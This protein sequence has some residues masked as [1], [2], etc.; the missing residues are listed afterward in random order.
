MNLINLTQAAKDHL[1]KLTSDNNKKYV[2][3]EVKG[4]GCAGFKYDWSF[5]DIIQDSD[6]HVDFDGFTLL[7]DR[8]SLLYLTGM[9]IE[10]KQQIFGSFLELQNPN[11]TSSCGCGESFGV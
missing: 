2:R 7:L 6:E 8:S 4:G 11:A 3:L 9:T 5:D 1:N 10:Y